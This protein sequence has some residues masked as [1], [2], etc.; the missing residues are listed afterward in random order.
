VAGMEPLDGAAEFLA[1]LR[2]RC[3]ALAVTLRGLTLGE[4]LEGKTK[5]LVTKEAWLG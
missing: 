1:W 2:K 5:G 3:Q 4:L